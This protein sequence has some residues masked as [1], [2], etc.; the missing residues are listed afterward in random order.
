M[1]CHNPSNARQPLPLLIAYETNNL[2]IP[3]FY[4]RQTSR[5]K[6][7]LV[8]DNHVY[9][10]NRKADGGRL[11]WLCS[12][13]QRTKC[14]VRCITFGN[15][16]TKRPSVAHN[17]P[18]NSNRVNFYMAPK[19]EMQEKVLF[20]PYHQNVFPEYMVSTHYGLPN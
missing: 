5:G 18:P 3:G 17:H 11:F 19:H 10:L 1:S 15:E 4:F 20:Q 8:C 6:P 16:M 7:C 14:T 9:F 2:P 12:E 13:Y